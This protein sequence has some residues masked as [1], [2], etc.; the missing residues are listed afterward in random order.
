MIGIPW[1]NLCFPIP[2]GLCKSSYCLFFMFLIPLPQTSSP[3][4]NLHQGP[5][6]TYIYIRTACSLS[7]HFFGS[8]ST[9]LWSPSASGDQIQ[10]IFFIFEFSASNIWQEQALNKHV[11]SFKQI[12][13]RKT[14]WANVHLLSLLGTILLE[15]W[16]ESDCSYSKSGARV[17]RTHTSK[18]TSVSAF[19]MSNPGKPEGAEELRSSL[20]S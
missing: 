18:V 20:C 6:F 3:V 9:R 12:H 2:Q 5:H 15:I 10:N 13:W 4:W 8:F 19:Y 7:I 16:L 11:Q 17:N 1:K 14:I